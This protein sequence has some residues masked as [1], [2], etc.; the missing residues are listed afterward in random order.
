MT[1]NTL[2]SSYLPGHVSTTDLL[3][4]WIVRNDADHALLDDGISPQSKALDWLSTDSIAIAESESSPR[5]I[6]QPYVL[7]VLYY[8][9][10]V[11]D[12]R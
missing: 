1:V 11:D 9:T 8:A 2:C 12:W 4:P 10:N 5:V 6:L 3:K 7:A